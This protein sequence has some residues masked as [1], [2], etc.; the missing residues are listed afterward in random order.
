MH[1]HIYY[2]NLIIKILSLYLL[3]IYLV[4]FVTF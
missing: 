2:Y 4:I 1:N 3:T